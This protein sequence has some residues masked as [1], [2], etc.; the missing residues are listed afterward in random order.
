[1]VVSLITLAITFGGAFVGMAMPGQQLAEDTKDVVRLGTGLVGTIAAL[2]LGLLIASAKSS[3][4]TQNSQVRQ[5]TADIILVDLLLTQYGSE[6]HTARDLLRRAVGP[7][8]ERI[9]HEGSSQSAKDGPFESSRA[10]E[11]AYAAIQE[12]S[13]QTDAQR[14]LKARALQISTDLA[15]TRLLLFTQADSSIPMPFLTVLVLWLTI[16]FASFGLF[17]R[18]NPTVIAALLIFALS[19]SGAIFLILELS[20]PF[21]GLMEISSAPLR[22]ALT[23]LSP[24]PD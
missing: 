19:A 21:E 12:L 10:A 7:L 22:N 20:Q 11:V 24:L 18:L 13:P 3:Y 9:W 1:M 23:P 8:V 2:V 14:A 6:A 4:D 17:S 5:I 16:I 15:Q